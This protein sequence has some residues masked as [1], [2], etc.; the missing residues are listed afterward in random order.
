MA[1]GA[2]IVSCLRCT[3]ISEATAPPE[4][5]LPDTIL[6]KITGGNRSQCWD[7]QE[8]VRRELKLDH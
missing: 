8:S 1:R 5:L 7:V 2:R 4:K 6:L 3:K